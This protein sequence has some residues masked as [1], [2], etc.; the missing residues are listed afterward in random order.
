[1][2]SNR[3]SK[4]TPEEYEQLMQERTKMQQNL[5]YWQ[6]QAQQKLASHLEVFNDAIIAIISTIMVLEIPLPNHSI[7]YFDFLHSIVLFLIS[8][9]IVINFWYKNHQISSILTNINKSYVI[10]NFI[11][12]ACL[13]LI[14]VLTKW[15]ME[16][17]TSLAVAHM[18][19]IYLLITTLNIVMS[20]IAYGQLIKDTSFISTFYHRLLKLRIILMFIFNIVLIIMAFIFPTYAMII[21]LAIP[22]LSLF[23]P[24]HL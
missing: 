6:Q 3:N 4:L 15:M 1:M 18:G 11:F 7:S 23:A 2:R 19:I 16:D 24:S 20:G 9:F 13:S 5:E 21:Y 8:F 10:L 14:P 12:V 17:S 22:I